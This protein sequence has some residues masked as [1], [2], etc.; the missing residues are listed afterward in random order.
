MGGCVKKSLD[1]LKV[2]FLTTSNAGTAFYRQAQFKEAMNR[3]KLA[4]AVIPWFNYKQMGAQ[5]WQWHVMDDPQVCARTGV[6]NS[7][8]K[9][10]DV[11][12]VQYLHSMEALALVEAIKACYPKKIFLTEIDDNVFETPTYN[13]AHDQYSPGTKFR[14]VVVEQIKALD[15]VICTT[16]HLADL[17][18]EFNPHV[19]QV[20]NAIDF[21]VWDKQPK[22]KRHDKIVRIGWAGAG[23]H[24]EDLK[25]IEAPMKEFLEETKGVELHLL[26]GIPE[27]FKGHPKVVCHKDWAYINKYP[28]RLLKMR[29]DVGLAPLVDNGFNRAKSNLRKLEYAA[30]G[31]PVLAAKVGHFARTVHHARD[32]FLYETPEEFKKY[33]KTLVE[34]EKLRGLMGRANYLDVKA[35]FNLN[36]VAAHYVEVLKQAHSKGQTT[37]VDVSDPRERGVKKWIAQ[38]PVLS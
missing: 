28:S 23:N 14:D 22:P 13:E 10:A 2:Y 9:E 36:D 26:H 27:F 31:V 37:T 11:I 30:M 19:Y 3:R 25:T 33:L 15:G 7:M 18:R 34:D 5:E 6:I 24:Y 17:C 8:A 35:N 32:G 16:P 29:L 1:L 21:D 38:Q 12:V 20:P 4:S